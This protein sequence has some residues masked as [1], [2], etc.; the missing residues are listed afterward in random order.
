[1]GLQDMKLEFKGLA[2]SDAKKEKENVKDKASNTDAKLG[3]THRAQ[4]VRSQRHS[5]M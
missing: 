1:M 5:T 3:A 2:I 4:P